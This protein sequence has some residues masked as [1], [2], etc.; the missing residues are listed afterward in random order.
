MIE[1]HFGDG[2]SFG[3]EIEYLREDRPLGTGGPL[4]LLEKRPE[5]PFFVLNGDQVMRADLSAMLAQHVARGHAA[6][7]GIGAHRVQIP[8]AVIS[9][10]N[11]Q[12]SA[13]EEKPTLSLMVNRGIYVLNPD[14]LDY[15]PA[16]QEFPITALFETLLELDKPIG[17]F[18]FEDYWLDVGAVA[19]LRTAN[20]LAS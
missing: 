17:T 13:L 9:T 2:S 10:E 5:H 16:D 1:S 19:D 14:T 6:T 18:Q 20:G 12:V 7:I 4:G 8:Y 11:G 3:C 15:V